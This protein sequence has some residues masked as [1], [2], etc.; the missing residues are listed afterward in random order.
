[1]LLFR[2]KIHKGGFQAVFWAILGL[3]VVGFVV[4]MV[5]F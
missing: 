1:M 3:Q 4:W 2:H 5:V